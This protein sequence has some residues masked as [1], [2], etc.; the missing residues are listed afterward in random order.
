M[1]EIKL[2]IL[3]LFPLFPTEITFIFDKVTL[4]WPYFT[5]AKLNQVMIYALL[6]PNLI[7]DKMDLFRAELLANVLAP[8]LSDRCLLNPCLIPSPNPLFAFPTQLFT[9]KAISSTRE[10]V[11]HQSRV[12]PNEI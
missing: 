9:I 8:L 7:S 6:R 1:L 5:G 12:H 10:Y 3:H 11:Q 2:I 4:R